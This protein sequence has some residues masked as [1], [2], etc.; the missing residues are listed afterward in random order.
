M[1][2][3]KL[4]LI[5]VILWGLLAINGCS[6]LYPRAVQET[7]PVASPKWAK[8]LVGKTVYDRDTGYSVVIKGITGAQKVFTERPYIGSEYLGLLDYRPYFIKSFILV[9]FNFER[10]DGFTNFY[11]RN[12]DWAGFK[13]EYSFTKPKLIPTVAKVTLNGIVQKEPYY[14]V[15]EQDKNTIRIESAGHE[16]VEVLAQK[17]VNNKSYEWGIKIY[18][19]EHW[20]NINGVEGLMMNFSKPPAR[21]FIPLKTE[22]DNIQEHLGPDTLKKKDVLYLRVIE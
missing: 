21:L 1:I 12:Y 15:L 5:A 19:S 10:E 4:Y 11:Q 6:S 18:G 13:E 14:L 8:N 22:L 17:L 3:K 2:T 9:S 16:P 7:L 20:T